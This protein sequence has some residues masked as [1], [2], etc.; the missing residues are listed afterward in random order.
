VCKKLIPSFYNSSY[1]VVTDILSSIQSKMKISIDG[2]IGSGKSTVMSRICQELRMP[3]FLEPVDEWKDWL[4]LFYTDTTRWGMS[5]NLK[6][7]M[8]FNKWKYINVPAVYE[9]SPMANRYV[10]AQLQ[11]ENNEMNDLETALFHELYKNFA[12]TPDVVIYIRTDPEVSMERM[13][14]RARD[15][16]N[17][18]PLEYLKAVHEKYEKLYASPVVNPKLTINNEICKVFTVDG[19]Q[20]ADYVY[21]QVVSIIKN[22]N[23]NQ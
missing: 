10:F 8:S 7:L 19:N 9:R 1:K 5:F 4:K 14:Q 13:K 17:C 12:W 20:D 6:V 18:V 16:E 3:V 23:T 22:L 11:S 21:N 15:C 2:N